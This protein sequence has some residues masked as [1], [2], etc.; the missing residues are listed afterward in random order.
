MTKQTKTNQVI[1]TKD[2]DEGLRLSQMEQELERVRRHADQLQAVFEQAPAFIATLDGA[3]HT[4]TFANSPTVALFGGRDIIGKPIREAM[5]ELEGQGFFELLDRVYQTGEPYIGEAMPVQLDR[6]NSG[7]PEQL[8]LHFVYQAKR[9]AQG[10][11]DGILV[12][13]V[14][15]TEQKAA[16]AALVEANAELSVQSEELQAQQE[17]LATLYEQ[18]QRTHQRVESERDRLFDLSLDLIATADATGYLTSVNPAWTTT[19][20]WTAEELMSRPF[21]E[22]IIPEDRDKSVQEITKLLVEGLPTVWFENRFF[23]K[24]GDVRT[25]DW[26]GYPEGG[27]IYAIARDVTEQKQYEYKL[28]E[29]NEQLTVQAEELQAQTE[30][31]QAQAQELVHHQT[32][33]ERAHKEAI[34]QRQLTERIIESAPT[35]I[36]YM[37][38]D[39]VYEWVNPTQAKLWALPADQVVGRSVFEVFGLDQDSEIGQLLRQVLETGEPHSE[40]DFPFTYMV[41]GQPR[42][43]LWDFTYQPVRGER[44]GIVG[45]LVTATEITERKRAEEVLRESEERYRGLFESSR[46][47]IVTASLERGIVDINPAFSRML[48]Y[49]LEEVAGK[50]SEP[51]YPNRERFLEAG[52]RALADLE[53]REP[54]VFETEMKRKDGTIFPVEV[55]S[56]LLRDVHGQ[57]SR[58]VG[59]LRDLTEQKR[60]EQQMQA[61]NRELAA[62]KAFAESLIQNIPTGVAY[63]DRDLIFRVANPVYADFLQIPAEQFIDRYLFDVLPS[64]REQIEPVLLQVLETGK[65]YYGSEFPFTYTTPEGLE[66]TTYWD[67]VY[68]PVRE[69]EHEPVQGIFALADEVS[70]RIEQQRE[71]RRLREEQERLQQERMEALEQSDKL[72]DQFL[73]I[74][75]HELRTPINAIMGFGSVLDDEVV[76][77]LSEG[78]H[79]YTR[80]ILSSADAL[81]ALIEDLLIVSRVQAGKFSISPQTIAFDEL[82]QS[83]LETQGPA[84]EKKAISLCNHVP[85]GLPVLMADPLRIEQVIN[86]LVGNAIKFTPD[87]GQV[88]IRASLENGMLR[89]EVSDTGIGIAKEDIPKLFQRFTQLDMSNT[90]SA[91]GAGLGLSI[92]KAIVDAHGGQVGIQS[93]ARQGATFWFTLPILK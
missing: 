28:V 64:D 45:I 83:A 63:L 85:D 30:E 73:S 91:S 69:N 7:Q 20:G 4:F 37:N 26:R 10:H 68:Y 57:P 43:T 2:A 70:D 38:R 18:L 62:Q 67:F 21:I 5:P 66:R 47:A 34:A 61:Y 53:R 27:V 48:G 90:R 40:T 46:D 22:F 50:S 77:P 82:V 49:A 29:A 92:V 35:G 11:I 36:S 24:G 60:A 74:L 32:E 17:E 6:N 88:V 16:E 79:A 12:H 93:E 76:G 56:Y 78:Q 59:V 71:Q 42:T 55:S 81:L 25:L 44:E 33:L 51:L 80:K 84:A 41:E 14:D 23:A 89:C 13:A 39:L 65:P 9:N 8:Y 19:L 1:K 31:L 86:N 54:V 58:L 72:K 52:R 3:E 15:V 87:G 75:S